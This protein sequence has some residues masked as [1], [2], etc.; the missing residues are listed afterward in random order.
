MY[1]ENDKIFEI[2]DLTPAGTTL[3]TELFTH[4]N[5]G[6]VWSDFAEGPSAIYASG[7]SNEESVIYKIDAVASTS[8][9]HLVS[10]YYGGRNAS[11]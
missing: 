1:A 2:T 11:W 9:S 6:W 8:T 10:T 7:Y 3:P 4:P 5:S